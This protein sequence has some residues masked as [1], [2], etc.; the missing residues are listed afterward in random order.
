[1]FGRPNPDYW[2][3]WIWLASWL[4]KRLLYGA[5]VWCASETADSRGV[6][7]HSARLLTVEDMGQELFKKWGW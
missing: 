4:P 6:P 2:S 1:M 3:V 5:L 7:I